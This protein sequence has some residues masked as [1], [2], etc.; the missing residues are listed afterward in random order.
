MPLDTLTR[1]AVDRDHDRPLSIEREDGS[2]ER[3]HRA[4]EAFDRVRAI[5]VPPTGAEFGDAFSEE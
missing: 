5:D 3:K 4:E 2:M 1:K